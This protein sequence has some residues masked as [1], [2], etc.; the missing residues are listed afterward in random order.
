VPH[1]TALWISNAS[2]INRNERLPDLQMGVEY[3]PSRL[4]AMETI[5]AGSLQRYNE[6]IDFKTKGRRIPLIGDT[7]DHLMFIVYGFGK[8]GK[9]VF[10]NTIQALLALL[11]TRAL[12]LSMLIYKVKCPMI[13]AALKAEGLVHDANQRRKR[14]L[15]EPLIKQLQAGTEY[16]ADF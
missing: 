12:R 1:K 10:I 2:F 15:N 9:S 14:K 7:N 3:N 5:F 8:N 16:V 6:L 11:G 4:S 13:L